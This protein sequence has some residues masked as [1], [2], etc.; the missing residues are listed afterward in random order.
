M[1]NNGE[2]PFLSINFSYFDKSSITVPTTRESRQ[3]PVAAAI[4][5]SAHFP[6]LSSDTLVAL[7]AADGHDGRV[8]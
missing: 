2:L 8:L 5:S 4:V 6:H 3:P 1:Y 7:A